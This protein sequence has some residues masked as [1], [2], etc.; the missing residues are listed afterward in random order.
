MT[1]TLK[2]FLEKLIDGYSDEAPDSAEYP[3]KVF[4]IKKISNEDNI[5]NYVLEVNVWDKN[6]TYS[7]AETIMDG[8][9]KKLDSQTFLEKKFLVYTY[10]GTR[11]NVPDPDKAIKRVRGQFEIR[12]VEREE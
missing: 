12:I 3:Y 2:K 9:E 10:L 5:S 11:N 6:K 7:R 8:L 1:V 4:S